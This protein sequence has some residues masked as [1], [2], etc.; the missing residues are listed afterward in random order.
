MDYYSIDIE[1][2]GPVPGRHSMLSLGAT[3]VRRKGG[4]Y[5]VLDDHY[6]ELRPVFAEFSEPAMQ[7]HGLDREQLE[8]HGRAPVD[9][10]SGLLEFVKATQ[11]ETDERPVFVAHNAPFDWMFVVYYL[12]HVGLPN[13]FGHSAL[14]TKA[15]AMGVLELSWPQTS[16]RQLA[17]R[18]PEVAP[19]QEAQIHHAG[20]DARYQ[21]EVF[22]ALMNRLRA[23]RRRTTG[24]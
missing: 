6:V 5:V 24:A 21:A 18:L 22:A 17:G 19:R 23:A 15:L 1:T 16:L 13:P 10:M 2:S 11:K 7:V 14:D 8:A 9:A 12:D 3:H 20:A 4:K